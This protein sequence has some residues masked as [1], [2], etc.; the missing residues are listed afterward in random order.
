MEDLQAPTNPNLDL[1]AACPKDVAPLEIDAQWLSRDSTIVAP[2]LIGC[3]LVRLMADGTILRGLIVETEAYGPGD[4]AMHAYRRAT[5]RNQ[6]MF[7]VAG[8]AYVYLIYGMYHCFNVV[9][10]QPNIPSAVLIRALQIETLPSWLEP[11]K[12]QRAAAGPGKLCRAFQIDRT[13]TAIPLQPGQ[14]LWLEHR[15]PLFQQQMTEGKLSLTQTT[16]IGL[17]Q[18]VELPW[19]WYLTD[20]PA[21]SRKG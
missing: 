3:T 18:G 19:R 9:T 5:A 20:C 2:E 6:V 1:N 8:V 7:G 11:Q 16:R 17:T 4:P 21:V 10:D 13:L 14:P 15:H 12:L